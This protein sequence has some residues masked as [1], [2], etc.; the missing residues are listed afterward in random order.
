[1]QHVIT[2][3]HLM[4]VLALVA[5]VLYQK[6]EGGALGLGQSGFFSGRGQANALTR[7]TGILATVFFITSILLTVMPAYER[8]A[9]GGGDWTK[10]VDQQNVQVKEIGPKTEPEASKEVQIPKEKESIFDQLKRAQEK[11]QS[12]GAVAPTTAP[13]PNAP[14][15]AP[16]AQAPAPAAPA[17]SAPAATT[18]A[19]GPSAPP[20]AESETPAL[21]PSIPETSQTPAPKAESKPAETTPWV[22][23]GAAPAPAE[24]A[25]PSA[26]AGESKPAET[27]PWVSPGAPAPAEAPKASAPAGESKDAAPAPA[28]KA[29][30]EWKS[31]TQ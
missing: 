23:P 14:A 28:P 18:P 31:P 22:S 21:R 10:A 26:P 7:T 27:T 25:K 11:R 17:P 19:P 30:T 2:A 1:M 29:P 20:A 15:T 9:S 6:S 8:R 16:E 5:L 4:V 12:G 3:I 24:A 13:E